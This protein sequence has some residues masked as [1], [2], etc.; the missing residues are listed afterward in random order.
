MAICPHGGQHNTLITSHL[1]SVS[2]SHPRCPKQ[3]AK[4]RRSFFISLAFHFPSVFSRPSVSYFSACFFLPLSSALSPSC[5]SLYLLLI[6]HLSVT[7]CFPHQLS[8]CLNMVSMKTN[9][10]PRIH[11]ICFPAKVNPPRRNEDRSSLKRTERWRERTGER[12]ER[13]REMVSKI[14]DHHQRSDTDM[15]DSFLAGESIL[16]I[17]PVFLKDKSNLLLQT[18]SY[19]HG[20]GHHFHQ[21]VRA[22]GEIWKHGNITATM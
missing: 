21:L 15:A 17:H 10:T 20:F 2:S 7:L 14:K 4:I 12:R 18:G 13:E 6:D 19:F 8:L 9:V 11:G 5:C 22:I 3:P 16:F 1:S